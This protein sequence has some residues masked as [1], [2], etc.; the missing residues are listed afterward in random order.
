MLTECLP[1]SRSLAFL[2]QLK[3]IHWISWNRFTDPPLCLLISYLESLSLCCPLIGWNSNQG[4]RMLTMWKELSCKSVG[5]SSRQEIAV[6]WPLP[7]TCSWWQVL[8]LQERTPVINAY[9]KTKLFQNSYYFAYLSEERLLSPCFAYIS[10]IR[11]VPVIAS[12]FR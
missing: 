5:Y 7:A 4:A 1:L 2:N 12:S 11:E 3:Q 8:L 10:V 9:R 6:S